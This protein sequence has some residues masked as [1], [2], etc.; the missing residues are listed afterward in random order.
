LAARARWRYVRRKPS[1]V[2]ARR[3]QEA[4]EADLAR[5]LHTIRRTTKRNALRRSCGPNHD[6]DVTVHSNEIL[7]SRNLHVFI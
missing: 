4:L 7:F 6:H 2:L 1:S 5:T 3:G